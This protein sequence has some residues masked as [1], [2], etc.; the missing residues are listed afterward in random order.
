MH[1]AVKGWWERSMKTPIFAVLVLSAAASPGLTSAAEQDQSTSKEA[2]LGEVVVTAEKVRER[3]IDVPATISVLTTTQLDNYALTSIEDYANYV[4]GL[5]IQGGDAP[6]SARLILRGINDDDG[7]SPLVATYLDGFPVGASTGLNRAFQFPV[8]LMPYDLER[9]EVLQGPQGTLYGA[10]AMGGLIK[11]VLR[12]PD[13]QDFQIQAGVG[14][15]SLDHSSGFGRTVRAALSGPIID[16]KLG[17]RLSAF[18][19]TVPGF[20]DNVGLGIKHENKNTEYGGRA[21]VLWKPTDAFK[22][23]VSAMLQDTSAD[24]L[25]AVTL[26]TT[27]FK[28]VYGPYTISTALPDGYGTRIEIYSIDAEW[29]LGIATLSNIASYQ[30]KNDTYTWDVSSLGALV[31]L[32]TGGAYP[33]EL[34]GFNF[35]LGLKKWTEE[36]R[37]TS[38]S[39]QRWRWMLGFFATGESTANDQITQ[40]YSA[41]FT[42]PIVGY[43][44]VLTAS[45]PATYRELA[46]FGNLTYKITDHLDVTGGVRY[47]GNR[48]T[49]VQTTSGLIVATTHVAASSSG[50]DLLGSFTSRYHFTANNMIYVSV[51]NGYR[52][53]GPNATYNNPAVPPSFGADKLVNYE[54]GFKG[55]LFD[56]KVV[57]NSSIFHIDW[58]NIQIPEETATNPPLAYTSNADTASSDG[59]ELSVAYRPVRSLNLGASLAYTNARLTADA[60]TLGGKSGDPLP[61]SPKLGGSLTADY[62]LFLGD[63]ASLTFGG[64]Y[65]YH[66]SIWTTLRSSA[67][68]LEFPAM[69]RHV[70]LYA[71]VKWKEVTVRFY[72]KNVLGEQSYSGYAV[73]FTTNGYVVDPPRTIGVSIDVTR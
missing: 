43:P 23:Q 73:P 11:Y 39:D 5:Y 59:M 24:M 47:A 71:D 56:G 58:S 8:D 50:T 30:N 38:S 9:I 65:R 69:K 2:S 48:Q 54:A 33:S 25:E 27:T 55:V 35:Q 62:S 41:P 49:Q 40:A 13:L 70:D 66:S 37:L 34:L 20:I 32:L 16:D 3:A 21:A 44:N 57:L 22:V 10:S 68:A 12:T 72:G 64:A 60:P 18:D 7:G 51:A 53:G 61:G 4:P 15:E 46:G 28:P 31:P 6:G 42:S 14:A 63:D 17:I 19:R 67:G 36:L 26:N 1:T 52:P 45:Y 29:N